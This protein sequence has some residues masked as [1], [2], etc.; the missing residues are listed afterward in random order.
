[1]PRPSSS[2]SPAKRNDAARLGSQLSALI[3]ESQALRHVLARN[4]RAAAKLQRELERTGSVIDSME[5]LIGTMSSARELPEA[6]DHFE[7]TRRR[8]RQ[9]L[10]ILASKQDVSLGEMAR[11]F[12]VSRQ[13]VSRVVL[14]ATTRKATS[15][16]ASSR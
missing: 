6:L 3:E 5:S 11:R 9:T 15:R 14:E 4:E 16:R 1:M 12:G 10:F 7:A 8:T 13:L 2:R